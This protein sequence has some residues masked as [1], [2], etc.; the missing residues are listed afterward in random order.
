MLSLE[1][2]IGR[3]LTK[4]FWAI[5]LLI[6]FEKPC[7]LAKNADFDKNENIRI[8]FLLKIHENLKN[9]QTNYFL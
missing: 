8:F 5:N 4:G 7:D 1:K 2:I 6:W 3:V 9:Y